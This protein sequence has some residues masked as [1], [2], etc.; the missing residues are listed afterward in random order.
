MDKIS[1]NIYNKWFDELAKD[2]K[3]T[4]YI[5]IK[6]EPQTS[7]KESLKEIDPVKVLI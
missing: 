4:G 3:V 6:A 5:Y 2:I 7:L 1:H